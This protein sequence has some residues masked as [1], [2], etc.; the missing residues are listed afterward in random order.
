M[1]KPVANLIG[2]RF[3]RLVVLS[4]DRVSQSTSGK[5]YFYWKCKCDCGATKSVVR[6]NLSSGSTRSCGCLG[7]EH[8]RGVQRGT[9]AVKHGYSGTRVYTVWKNMIARCHNPTN[10]SYKYYGKVG[11]K[12]CKRWRTSV[13]NFVEDMGLP[14]STDSIDR[15]DPT[16]GYS[17]SN[18]R[19]LSIIENRSRARKPNSISK[20]TK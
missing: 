13:K 19:W 17:K 20:T 18:C 6:N 3:G 14:N 10:R 5:N 2:K 4:L 8:P 11:V 7:K 15:K 12:V 1:A 9:S 16:K